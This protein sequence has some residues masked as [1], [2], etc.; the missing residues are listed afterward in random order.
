MPFCERVVEMIAREVEEVAND[1]VALWTRGV[2]GLGLGYP[3]N[4][5]SHEDSTCERKDIIGWH[6]ERSSRRETVWGRPSL[7]RGWMHVLVAN[8]APGAAT[9][10][11]H[12]KGWWCLKKENNC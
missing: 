2:V 9:R 7:K 5:K 10:K 8:I 12:G 3:T 11:K 4:P 1:R 6:R